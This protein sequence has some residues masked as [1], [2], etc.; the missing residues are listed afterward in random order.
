MNNNIEA[1]QLIGLYLADPSLSEMDVRSVLVQIKEKLEQADE[2]HI[3]KLHNKK[4]K[5]VK[6]IL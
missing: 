2:L 1:I 6:S 3:S 4:Y 5:E